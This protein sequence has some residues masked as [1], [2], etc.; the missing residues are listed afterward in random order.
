MIR[1]KKGK[2]FSQI[3]RKGLLKI[4][5]ELALCGWGVTPTARN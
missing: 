4:T 1:R 2:L 5:Y 3:L